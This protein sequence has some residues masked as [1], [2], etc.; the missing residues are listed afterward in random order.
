M[1]GMKSS[2]LPRA[3]IVLVLS[4]STVSG[5]GSVVST[6][7]TYY[8]DHH[9]WLEAQSYCRQHH[10]DLAVLLKESDK[11]NMDMNLYHAWFG[12]YRPDPEVND[13]VWSSGDNDN[14]PPWSQNEPY[15][16]DSCA[17]VSYDSRRIRGQDCATH[18]FFFCHEIQDFLWYE[19]IPLSKNWSE[20]QDYCR[21]HYTD[22][23][24]FPDYIYINDVGAKNFPV[25]IGLH[26]EEETWKWSAGFSDYRSWDQGEPDNSSGCVS[27]SSF[28]KKMA[29]KNCNDSY[30][31]I[32]SND[33]IVVVK[34]NK[35]W[36]EALEHCRAL[37]SPSNSHDVYDLV[38][39]QPGDD[40]DYVM[41][42]VIEADTEEVWVSLRFLAGYW[43][44][45]TGADMLY[46]DLPACPLDWKHCGALSKA[47]RTSVETRDC[48]ERKNFLC[49]RK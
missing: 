27:I 22:L 24:T 33:N 36:E 1:M 11:D 42:R 25:W 45:V 31:F 40:Q 7:Y 17:Y 6:Y 49:Y 5:L 23:A 28:E 12:L 21:Q 48:V 43:R 16:T 37:T 34:E 9:T 10:R 29:T 41:T 20:A 13:W 46:P 44:W 19:F 8:E 47:N 30:P 32:C 38:S 18:F 39:V 4:S 15:H 14:F 3:L 2:S 35:T 26:E